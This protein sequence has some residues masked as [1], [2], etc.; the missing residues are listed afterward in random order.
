MSQ[1]RPQQIGS[2][3]QN[4]EAARY[5]DPT[6]WNQFLQTDAGGNI[7]IATA[8]LSGFGK[9]QAF[10][11]GLSAPPLAVLD[12]TSMAAG[13]GGALFFG[14]QHVVGSY[15]NFGY[16]RGLKENGTSGDY[17]GSIALYTR[18]NGGSFLEQLRA[19]S[20][21]SVTPGAD[22][23]QDF[24]VSSLRWRRGFFGRLVTGAATPTAAVAAG[25]GTS[26]SIAVDTG[27]SD[28]AGVATI[29]VG[30]SPGATGSVTITFS[31]GNGAYGTNTP[32][33]QITPLDGANAWDTGVT[34]KL[35]A[36]STTSF[37]VAFKNAAT[38]LTASGTYK[39][40]WHV[41]GK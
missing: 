14:G 3:I 25:F 16:I 31:T 33:V 9:L 30:T 40:A 41:V 32:S 7:A 38:N 36:C 21:R 4:L 17:A 28:L 23:A 15:Q 27:S 8:P 39:F 18:A 29:T 12:T 13:V 34:Y 20:D 5:G 22:N 1:T 26:P 10:G 11:T 24:G 6:F 2:I 19:W 35:T 37:T